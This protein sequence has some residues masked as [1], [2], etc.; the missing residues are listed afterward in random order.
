[1]PAANP[2]A[3][4]KPDLFYAFGLPPAEA[5]KYFGSKGL[6][7]TWNWEQSWKEAN[8]RAFTVAKMTRLDLLADVYNAL[9]DHLKNGGSLAAFQDQLTP[10]MKAKGW[11]GRKEITDRTTGEITKVTLGTPARLAVIYDT[12]MQTAYMAGRETEMLKATQ[13]APWWE[14]VAVM[15]ARTRPA[16]A[17]MNGLVFR[18]D[19]AFWNS[20]YPPNGF[21]C[22]CRVTSRTDIAHERGDFTTSK[23]AG[24]MTTVD[25]TVRGK[26]G[27]PQTV[28]S[29]AYKDPI[30]GK[31]LAPDAGWDYNPGKAGAELDKLYKQKL[32][33]APAALRKRAD[34]D[35]N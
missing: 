5:V 34:E 22:R 4:E 27:Q 17:A 7:V 12:N 32:A 1:M 29:A 13:Y 10:L 23:S 18:Y 6:K 15:D 35:K 19:D 30:T 3:E 24:H 21:R 16:H 14:Y 26:D 33:D 8:A 11:W 9:D 28:T 25:Y 20:F 2:P 31:T